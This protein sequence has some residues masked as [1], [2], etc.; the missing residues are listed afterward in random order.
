MKGGSS[1]TLRK[2]FLGA[3]LFL[4]LMSSL[5]GCSLHHGT[6]QEEI[7]QKENPVLW[8]KTA[9]LEAQNQL[10]QEAE[11]ALNARFANVE[12]SLVR[13]DKSLKHMEGQTRRL[14]V[15]LKDDTTQLN[16]RVKRLEES[17]VTA[18]KDEAATKV[19]QVSIKVLSGTGKRAS[20]EKMVERL[21]GLGYR[22]D[23]IDMAPRKTFK[24]NVVFYRESHGQ[25]AKEMAHSLGSGTVAKPMTWSS[26]YGL[27][28]VSAM[29]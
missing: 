26:R 10:R 22:V 2:G 24:E 27:I 16:E 18:R 19:G 9:D 12:G 3:V 6:T 11:A 5:T 28:V 8:K 21:F 1:M 25:T 15:A 29:P 23:R 14:I 7:E 13:I 4:F 20:A 17:A